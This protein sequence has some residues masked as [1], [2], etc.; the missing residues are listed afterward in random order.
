LPAKTL[1]KTGSVAAGDWTLE[2]GSPGAVV[3]APNSQA[4]ATHT[5]VL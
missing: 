4:H 5:I 3:A 2:A 1:V